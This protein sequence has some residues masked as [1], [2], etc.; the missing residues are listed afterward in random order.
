MA[1]SRT[2]K[3]AD[4]KM[5]SG[6]GKTACPGVFLWFIFLIWHRPTANPT[7]LTINVSPFSGY[8]LSVLGWMGRRRMSN[9]SFCPGCGGPLQVEQ[10]SMTGTMWRTYTCSRCG[11]SEDVNEGKATWKIMHN[12]NEALEVEEADKGGA[13]PKDP[14]SLK[15]AAVVMEPAPAPT[16]IRGL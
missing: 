5:F 7:I 4:T 6:H 1:N 9:F 14:V 10:D 12:H 11:W 3:D 15:P 16:L 2:R 13:A 8:R